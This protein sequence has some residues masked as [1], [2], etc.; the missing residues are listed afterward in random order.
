MNKDVTICALLYGDYPQLASRCLD[1][2]RSLPKEPCELRI[3]LNAVS[4]ATRDIVDAFCRDWQAANGTVLLY[5]S[6][7]NIYKCPM[8]RQMFHGAAPVTTPYVM[9]FD[10]DSYR[11]GV[12]ENWLGMVLDAMRTADLIGAMYRCRLAGNQH[13]WLRDQPWYKGVP[14]QPRQ[15]IFFPTGGWWTI[16][17]EIL[18]RHDF[19]FL[20]MNYGTC[21][22]DVIL[23]ALCLQQGYRIGA[24]REGLAINADANGRESSAQRRGPN[25][26]PL[27]Y[28]Y[29]P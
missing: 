2:L 16:R 24:F 25:N 19:P 18:K 4:A 29:E 22:E 13:L 5:P 10:D 20:D 27:G 21:G 17:T 15:F 3:G 8:M 6:E 14:V 12:Y 26:K 7:T 1:S 28:F 9:W 11:I 23:G